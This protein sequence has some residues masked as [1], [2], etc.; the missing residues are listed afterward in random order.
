MHS[1]ATLSAYVQAAFGRHKHVD[2]GSISEWAQ[3][4]V[5]LIGPRAVWAAK[6]ASQAKVS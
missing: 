6:D 1:A 2:I 5:Y 4:K 3:R